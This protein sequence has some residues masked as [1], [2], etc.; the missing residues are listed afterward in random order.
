MVTTSVISTKQVIQPNIQPNIEKIIPCII[1]PMIGE[2]C[3]QVSFSYSLPSERL[4]VAA[5]CAATLILGFV[6]L[7][8]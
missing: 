7:F 6:C 4:D 8:L 1:Q 5:L 3:N 2:T